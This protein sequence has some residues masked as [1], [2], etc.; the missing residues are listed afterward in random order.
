MTPAAAW[1]LPVPV[2][3]GAGVET[4]FLEARPCGDAEGFH[5]FEQ[6][7]LL[8]GVAGE[9]GRGE[10]AEQSRLVYARLLALAAARGRHLARVWNY[11]PRINE[12]GAGGLENYRA[13]CRGRAE[14]FEAALGAGYR[15]VL[16]AASAVGTADGRLTVVFAAARERPR[17]AENPAQVPAY[18]YPSEHGPRSPSFARGTISGAH[19]FISG[20]AAIKG[21]AT[22]APDDLAGQLDCT[23]DN[24]RLISSA[25]GEGEDL[26]ASSAGRA[27]HF[28]VYLRHAADL[29]EAAEVLRR[30]LLRPEDRV[31]WLQADICRA[32]LR[33]E[34]E[35]TLAAGSA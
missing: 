1:I 24:L 29:A 8:V 6:G 31:S 7:D 16:P 9:A 10:L 35:A 22:V 17:H 12:T 26:G 2:L 19:V 15:R 27:R 14:A 34:I 33:V 28:K 20:T 18:A 25:C 5:L 30:R 23:L 3:D 32:A 11:V 21:H 4:L 13:F